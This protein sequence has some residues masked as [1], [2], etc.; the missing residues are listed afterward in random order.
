MRWYSSRRWKA[1]RVAV[2]LVFI[3]AVDVDGVPVGCQ[4]AGDAR[5][6]ANQ[7]LGAGPGAEAD[8]DLV[9]NGGLFQALGAAIVGGA[10]AH[11]L[12]SGAQGE[13][14]QQV[15]VA[16]AEEVGQRLLNLFRGVDFALAQAGAQLFDGD[17]DVDD[18]VGALEEAVGNGLAN[19]G[20][21]GA[22]DGV[23]QRFEMLD[24]DRGPSR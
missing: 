10:F 20:V 2:A 21:G 16:F 6:H 5:A 1:L 19:D 14:A 12:G 23:V 4:A 22:I 18:F 9:G 15:Q 8:H 11:L 24:V 13:L 3:G 7:P 17:V